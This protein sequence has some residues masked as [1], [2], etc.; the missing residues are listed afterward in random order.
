[1]VTGKELTTLRKRFF[2]KFNTFIRLKIKKLGCY[3]RFF[4]FLRI[5]K[6]RTKCISYLIKYKR[7]TK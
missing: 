4:D 6:R 7:K 1:M 3:Q 2:K 5:A